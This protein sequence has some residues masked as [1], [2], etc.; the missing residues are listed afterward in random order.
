MHSER[1]VS[2]R[3]HRSGGAGNRLEAT[4][5]EATHP[6]TTYYSQWPVGSGSPLP[7][8]RLLG[9]LKMG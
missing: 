5:K 1:R 9:K 2:V 7:T 4:Q 8:K 3:E 6:R